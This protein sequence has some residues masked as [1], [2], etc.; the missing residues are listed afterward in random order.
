MRN[1]KYTILILIIIISIFFITSCSAF[2]N[3]SVEQSSN[4]I[5]DDFTTK[6]SNIQDILDNKIT[7]LIYFGRDSCP[8]C[9]KFNEVLKDEI[10][11]NGDLLIYKFDTDYWREN[12]YFQKVLKKFNISEI[13]VLI[14]VNGNNTFN[15]FNVIGNNNLSENLRI[16]LYS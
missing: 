12:Q 6:I 14:K 7:G 9:I 10:N 16:F 13:P 15:T 3:L 1:F 8:I 5:Y 2:N 4:I 11:S